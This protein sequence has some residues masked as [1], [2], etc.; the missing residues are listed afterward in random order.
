MTSPE[1]SASKSA[2][3]SPL[4]VI[5]LDGATFDVI[6]PMVEAG[7]LPNLARFMDEGIAAPLRSTA[8]P[9]TFPAWSSFMTGLEPGRHG[10]FDFT[11]KISGAYRVAFANAADRSGRSIFARVSEAGGR[12]LVLGVPATFP[13]EELNGL[14]VPGFDA[15]VSTGS[16]ADATND[17]ALY[18]R[19]EAIAGPWMRPAMKEGSDTSLD[20]TRGHLLDRVDRKLAFSVA[21]IEAMREEAADLDFM[22]VVFSESDTVG[23][24]FWRHHDPDSPRHDPTADATARSTIEDVYSR[25]DH[26]CGE[27]RRAF[28]EE[29]LCVVMSDHGMGGASRHVVHLNRYLSEAGLLTRISVGGPSV[30]ALARGLRDLALKVLPSGLAQFIFRRARAAAARL[31]SGARFGGFDWN[32]TLAFSEEANTNPGVWINLRGREAKGAVAPEDYERV[33]DRVIEA[34]LA[35]RLPDGEPVVA[36][37]IRREDLYHGP[38]VS[39]APDIMIELALHHGYGLSLV[40]SRWEEGGGSSVTR[41]ED[42][43]LAGGRGLGMNGTHRADGI[44]IGTGTGLSLDEP[45]PRLV[46]MAPTLL[47]AMGL[48]WETSEGSADGTSHGI[49]ERRYSAEEEAAVADR[50]RAL[51]Y[52]D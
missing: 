24:H 29:S 21:A 43:E 12:V 31:E 45:H 48:D 25:L 34:L 15:P 46:D 1:I 36:R 9:V 38:F 44:L 49:T 4:L 19:I 26:A 17:P 6:R 39:R 27:L 2:K 33:R 40:A 11:Q 35:W 41:L 50:L 22:M 20:R 18:K 42:D 5:G 8:P 13:P 23:H 52:L 14:L 28:G 30:D 37:A 3:M 32:H 16:D 51:G 10:M 47:G 7:K